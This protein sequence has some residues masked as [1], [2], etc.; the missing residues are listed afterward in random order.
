VR[1][2]RRTTLILALA[3]TLVC[4]GCAHEVVWLGEP[5]PEF[6]S[7]LVRSPLTVGV[8]AGEFSNS[9]LDPRGV[10]DRFAADLRQA[11]LF[12]GIMYPVPPGVEPTWEIRLTASDTAVE[13][14][15]NLWWSALA[16][17]LPPAAL[18][19]T[20]RS[21]YTLEL[22]AL[23]VRERTLVTSYRAQAAIQNRWQPY[24]NTAEAGANG[25]QIAVSGA[26]REILAA[27]SRDLPRLAEADQSYVPGSSMKL[28][29]HEQ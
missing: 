19:V 6:E 3:G 16:S 26:T 13:P 14:N 29:E 8:V 9:R 7:P 27:L 4:A 18:F 20:L 12:E 24:A 15:A 22:E 17:A 1:S 10:L 2:R 28:W 21:D 23:V 25:V 11:A 5:A